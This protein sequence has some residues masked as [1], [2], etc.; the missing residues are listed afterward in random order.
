M[1]PALDLSHHLK[2]VRVAVVDWFFE[3]LAQLVTT[4]QLSPLAAKNLNNYIIPRAVMINV[5]E[6]WT[7][8]DLS[9]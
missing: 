1:V 6:L 3:L 9:Q 7:A 5:D 8:L 2:T 4:E